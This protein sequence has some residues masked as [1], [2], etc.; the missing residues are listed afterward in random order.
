MVFRIKDKR[1]RKASHDMIVDM[2]LHASRAFQRSFGYTF[3]SEG[4]VKR[5]FAHQGQDWNDVQ[6]KYRNKDE[7]LPFENRVGGEWWIDTGG[8]GNASA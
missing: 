7:L 2:A 3:K 8:S 6:L 1:T 4:D 5:F